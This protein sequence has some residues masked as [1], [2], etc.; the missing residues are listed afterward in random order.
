MAEAEFISISSLSSP[1]RKKGLMDYTNQ[2]L[3]VLNGVL[4]FKA[5]L[6]YI[7]ILSYSEKFIV[8]HII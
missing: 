5:F 7:Y 3:F 1:L 6:K 2:C 4:A 8:T